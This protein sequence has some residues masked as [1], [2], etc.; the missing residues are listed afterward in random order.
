MKK[1]AC[2]YR[3]WHTHTR[4]ATWREQDEPGVRSTGGPSDTASMWPRLYHF[5]VDYRNYWFIYL[6]NVHRY[7]TRENNITKGNSMPLTGDK[8]TMVASMQVTF[9]N[10]GFNGEI[11]HVKIQ[12]LYRCIHAW[13]MHWI[14]THVDRRKCSARALKPFDAHWCHMGTAIKHPMPSRVKPSFVI[15]DIRA[16]SGCFIAVPMWHHWASKG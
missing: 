15:F 1:I 3:Q 11:R 5:D 7:N 8:S 10:N 6:F 14:H 12:I 16:L 9:N 2:T 13:F 4:E